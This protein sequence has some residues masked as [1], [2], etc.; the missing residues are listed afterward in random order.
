MILIQIDW[1]NLECIGNHAYK[2]ACLQVMA[3]RLL[4]AEPMLSAR[5]ANQSEFA[6]IL[7]GVPL[8]PTENCSVVAATPAKN[9]ATVAAFRRIVAERF[10]DVLMQGIPE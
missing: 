9:V 3:N 1:N 5:D 10:W 4:T 7:T 8:S 2:T 6:A